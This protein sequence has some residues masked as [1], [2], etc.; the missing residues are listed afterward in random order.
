MSTMPF[1]T[2]EYVEELK[3]SGVPE[4]HAKVQVRL[5][6]KALIADIATKWDMKS[7]EAMTLIEFEK[8]RGEIKALESSTKQEMIKALE[9]STKVSI[10]ESKTETIKWI[11][12]ILVAQAGF[13]IAAIKLL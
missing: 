9:S 10:S 8:I 3:M 12:G 2:S 4:E 6:A 11:A 7:L 5:L 13:I 1:D